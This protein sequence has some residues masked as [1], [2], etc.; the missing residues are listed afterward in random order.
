MKMTPDDEA[1][2]SGHVEDA[3]ETLPALAVWVVEDL[4]GHA[5]WDAPVLLGRFSYSLIVAAGEMVAG[6]G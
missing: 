2:E 6:S 3:A 5:E 1:K 4:V